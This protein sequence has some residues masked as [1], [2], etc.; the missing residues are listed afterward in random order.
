MEINLQNTDF[1]SFLFQSNSPLRIRKLSL[2]KVN[3]IQLFLDNQ[4]RNVVSNMW[5]VS[6]KKKD[7]KKLSKKLESKN[8]EET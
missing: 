2:A 8:L 5:N 4:E 7:S 3:F 6:Y 1:F